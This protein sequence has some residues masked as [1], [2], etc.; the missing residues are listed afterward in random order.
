MLA[1]FETDPG[2]R[3]L[4]FR[5]PAKVQPGNRDRFQ[6]VVRLLSQTGGRER[7]RRVRSRCGSFVVRN[8]DKPV[9]DGLFALESGVSKGL[10]GHLRIGPARRARS[11]CLLS[12]RGRKSAR[13]NGE[14][15]FGIIAL[16]PDA[17]IGRFALDRGKTLGGTLLR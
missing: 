15:L 9:L 14:R 13:I 8:S 17:P 4:L 3:G 5:V 10:D 1:V 2:K 12:G 7:K 16:V 11:F 6:G